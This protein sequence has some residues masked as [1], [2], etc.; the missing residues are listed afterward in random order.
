MQAQFSRVFISRDDYPYL[1]RYLAKRFGEVVRIGND[2]W[3]GPE[4]VASLLPSNDIM[5]PGKSVFAPEVVSVEKI[6]N[7]EK[8]Y[9]TIKVSKVLHFCPR[10]LS[11]F[12]STI[13][14]IQ[15]VSANGE[16]HPIETVSEYT[17]T[18]QIPNHPPL[19]Q[20]KGW[21]TREQLIKAFSKYVGPREA[22][23]MAD[24]RI[25]AYKEGIPFSIEEM[26]QGKADIP[27]IVYE[28]YT[29]H[30]DE[31]DARMVPHISAKRAFITKPTI[32]TQD[33]PTIITQTRSRA[34]QS[35]VMY[36][37]VNWIVKI[38]GVTLTPM[39]M[40][41]LAL[42][43]GLPIDNGDC[44]ASVNT[45][46]CADNIDT[47]DKDVVE[48]VKDVVYN[49]QFNSKEKAFIRQ[50]MKRNKKFASAVRRA[51]LDLAR[52]KP[53]W[54]AYKGPKSIRY[55]TTVTEAETV[56]DQPKQDTTDPEQEKQEFLEKFNLKP[57]D[58]VEQNGLIKAIK[59]VITPYGTWRVTIYN[60]V[61]IPH[62]LITPGE[63]PV[64]QTQIAQEIAS[65]TGG[66]LAVAEDRKRGFKSLVVICDG[67]YTVR[68]ASKPL[69]PSRNEKYATINH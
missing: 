52:Y 54:K 26:V 9:R 43:L 30:R 35:H 21:M 37:F 59:M 61:F 25:I 24:L 17:Y 23:R 39:Q 62:R 7:E 20:R 2:F 68:V 64:H 29:A 19:E 27:S 51:G 58:V 12:I 22:E 40:I 6:I 56:Q 8:R 28:R 13:K 63:F 38:D 47:D 50:M 65:N 55:D 14:M 16:V 45:D 1:L 3:K 4:L 31:L 69:S 10:C 53:S 66:T 18:K 33:K 42:R 36:G 46:N 44:R 49:D 32:N 60:T 67:K 15:H 48:A 41:E 34:I 5:F 57:A 11:F